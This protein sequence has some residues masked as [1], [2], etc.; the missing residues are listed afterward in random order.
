MCF[1]SELM[2]F[3]TATKKA[4]CLFLNS[5]MHLK[6]SLYLIQTFVL[7]RFKGDGFIVSV[8]TTSAFHGTYGYCAFKA[9]FS[10]PLSF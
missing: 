4:L 10:I 5:R 7:Q 6:Y 9:T 2:L 3:L 8:S 1:T